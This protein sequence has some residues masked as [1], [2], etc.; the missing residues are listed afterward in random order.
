MHF[1]M[2]ERLCV[3]VITLPNKSLQRTRR[4]VTDFAKRKSK[5]AACSPRR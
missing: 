2:I 4:T 3:H 1:P 5:I